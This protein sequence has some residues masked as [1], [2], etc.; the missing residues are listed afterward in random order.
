MPKDNPKA[1][2]TADDL[3]QLPRGFF[4][5]RIFL[6]AYELGVFTALGD[7]RKTSADVAE[8]LGTD[9][10]AT[11]RL[12]NASAVLGLLHKEEGRFANAEA[13]ARYLVK[14]KAEY[15]SGLMHTVN[16]WD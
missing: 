7:G 13:A 2:L 5:S 10:R 11:D 6:T 3:Y 4:H 8:E 1:E 12:M 16:L 9:P 15:M 14:G